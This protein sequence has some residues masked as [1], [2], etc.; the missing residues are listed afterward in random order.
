[1][2]ERILLPLDGSE[3]AEMALPYG[4]ELAR[5]LGSELILFHVRGQS[6]GRNTSISIKYIWK[7]G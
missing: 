1:M 6:T 7:D 5:S 4:E 3:I 2:F